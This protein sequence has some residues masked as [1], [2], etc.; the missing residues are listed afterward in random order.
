MSSAISRRGFVGMGTAVAA[1]TLFS[2][3]AA[4]GIRPSTRTNILYIHSHDSGRYLAPYGHDVPTPRLLELAQGGVLLRQMNCAA[5]TCSPSRAAMLTGQSAHSAGMLG[6]AHLGWSLTHP[7]RH[8]IHTLA[9]HG[10]HTVL[11][12]LQHVA[13]DQTTIGY[14]K[15]L[16]H[17][18][19]HVADV[20]PGVLDYLKKAAAADRPFFLDIGFE[21]THRPYHL[22]TRDPGSLRSPAPIP[23]T[24]ET[25]YDMAGYCASAR[26]LDDGVGQVLNALA[27]LGLAENTLVIST[28][29]HGIAFPTM[30]CGLRDT[31]I[32]VSM[33]LRGPGAFARPTVCDALLSQ[34]D[35]FPTLCD[36]LGIEKPAWLEG[37]SF[38][39]IIEGTRQE[40]R[41]EVMA[42]V[43][44]HAAYEPKRAVRTKR[45]KY[46]RRFGDRKTPVIVNCDDGPSKTLW[47]KNGW[48]GRRVEEDTQGEELY[49]LLFDPGEHD[50]L[51][52][53][54]AMKSVL[55][56]MRDRLARWMRST[57]D[58]LMRGPIA[59]PPGVRSWSPDDISVESS[60]LK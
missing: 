5:P 59:L 29:D 6:L 32:G 60:E 9:K 48:A 23:D 49:D 56:D 45:Y 21:E 43:N 38:L 15:I 18:S 31:G 7:E 3:A 19:N 2:N 12:G 55:D 47:L 4:A 28:T 46:I 1:G 57:G 42:E 50:N 22:P 8:I 33:I 14:Q 27:Q 39:P 16:P 44:F 41:D 26:V 17:K 20:V 58:P 40:V 53:M 11:A 13:R 36:Y 35:L 54:P 30:K 25:R 24:P 37:V 34:I 52:A 51:A 10:Y